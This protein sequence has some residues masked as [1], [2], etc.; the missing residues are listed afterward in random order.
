MEAAGRAADQVSGPSYTTSDAVATLRAALNDEHTG[1]RIR[2]AAILF[3]VVVK[4]NLDV[5]VRS[6]SV[7]AQIISDLGKREAE[8]PGAVRETSERAL[9]PGTR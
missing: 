1:H 3:D 6:Y 2:A 9:A 7:P 8:A 5:R 4:V